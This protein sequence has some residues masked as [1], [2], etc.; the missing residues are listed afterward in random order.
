MLVVAGLFIRSMQALAHDR[1]RLRSRSSARGTHGCAQHGSVRRPAA[2]LYDRVL[3]RLRVVPGVVSASA[4][5]NGPLGTSWRASSLVD[6]GL[7]AGGERAA[8]DQRRVRDPDYFAT[9]GL[10][11]VEGR[12]FTRGRCAA[13]RAQAHRQRD[14][15]RRFF[16]NGAV[17]KRLDDRRRACARLAGDRG[18]RPGCKVHTTC[19][20]QRRTCSIA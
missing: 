12:G 19:G 1:R 5:L 9:V 4:S 8:V 6:R 14:M 3:E 20:A 13:R 11:I 17:G 10:A 2:A 18:R 7:H 16:P 15:A